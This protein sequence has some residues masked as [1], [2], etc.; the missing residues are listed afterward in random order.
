[1]LCII[2][3]LLKVQV[4]S[5]VCPVMILLPKY[6]YAIYRNFHALKKNENFQ[7]KKL[8]FLTF[9]LKIDCG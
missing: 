5:E 6:V 7:W 9:N 2:L 3:Q 4:I 8:I 1:M